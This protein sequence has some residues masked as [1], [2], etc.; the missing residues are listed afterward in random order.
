MARPLQLAAAIAPDP[1]APNS[2]EVITPDQVAIVDWD[3][4]ALV[5]WQAPLPDDSAG[6][7]IRAFIRRGGSAIF[8]PPRAPGKNEMF[9]SR[10]TSWQEQKSEAPVEGWRSDQDLLSQTQSGTPL[11]V[12]QLQVRRSCGLAGGELTAL[13]T[14]REAHLSWPAPRPTADRP[15][16]V[17]P[18]RPAVTPRWRPTAWSSMSWFSGRWP[19]VPRHS[20]APGSSWPENPCGKIP[21]AG[22]G[23]AGDEQAHLDRVRL[24]SRR[25]LLGRE[26][27]GGESIRGRGILPRPGR[28]PPR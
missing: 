12:G 14:L 24:P 17:P 15:T 23:V 25:L 27:P 20:G 8:F 16:S 7:P 2:A 3:Q 11:P 22:S 9:G 28:P 5:L 18:R 6:E 1:S 26:A 21:L 10:W 13:A 4:I 19:A